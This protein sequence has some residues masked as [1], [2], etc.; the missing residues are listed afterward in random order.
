MKKRE[1]LL[2]TIPIILTIVCTMFARQLGWL[3]DKLLSLNMMWY[4]A[5][6][7]IINT[8]IMIYLLTKIKKWMDNATN[9]SHPNKPM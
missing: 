6:L 2:W 8:V 7:L 4:I 9:I 3:G 5:I 1:I